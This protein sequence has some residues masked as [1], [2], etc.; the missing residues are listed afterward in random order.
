[1]LQAGEQLTSAVKIA[2]EKSGSFWKNSRAMRCVAVSATPDTVPAAPGNRFSQYG[3]RA[4]AGEVS[5]QPV[6]VMPALW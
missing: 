4:N 3:D 2:D 1:M 5:P 6:L